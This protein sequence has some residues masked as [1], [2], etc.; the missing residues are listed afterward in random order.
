[1]AQKLKIPGISSDISAKEA[2]LTEQK[3]QS[4]SPSPS[5]SRRWWT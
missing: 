3:I 4:P 2:E 1:M 5:R